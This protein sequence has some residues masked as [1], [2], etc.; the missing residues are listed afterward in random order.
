M[1][2]PNFFAR[3][4]ELCLCLWG[5]MEERKSLSRRVTHMFTFSRSLN[6]LPQFQL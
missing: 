3:A 6:R 5:D 1:I 4:L 2:L